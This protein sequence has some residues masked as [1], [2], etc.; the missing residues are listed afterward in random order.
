[1][2]SEASLSDVP[3]VV[4]RLHSLWLGHEDGE[5]SQQNVNLAASGESSSEPVRNIQPIGNV[6]ISRARRALNFLCDEDQPTST[7][8]AGESSSSNGDK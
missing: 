2:T 4:S 8:R 6:I 1:M 7:A 5:E 3:I